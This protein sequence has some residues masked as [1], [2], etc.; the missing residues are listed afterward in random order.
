MLTNIDGESQV[1]VESFVAG[2]EFS[3]I[4]VEDP[5]GEPLAL[6]PPRS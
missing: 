5:N 6:P 1:L 4:V 3:C 2:R